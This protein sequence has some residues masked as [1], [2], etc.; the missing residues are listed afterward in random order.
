MAAAG[1]GIGTAAGAL[2]REAT[3]CGRSD[4][5]SGSV[6]LAAGNRIA[7]SP[8]RRRRPSRTRAPGSAE[9]ARPPAVAP[10][11]G[12]W[13]AFGARAG[14]PPADDVPRTADS[15]LRRSGRGRLGRSSRAGPQRHGGRGH[16]GGIHRLAATGGSAPSRDLEPGVQGTPAPRVAA[17]S[18]AARLAASAERWPEADPRRRHPSIRRRRRSP[19]EPAAPLDPPAPDALPVRRRRRHPG[20]LRRAASRRHAAPI[21]RAHGPAGSAAPGRDRAGMAAP[22]RRSTAAPHP[23]AEPPPTYVP[24]P[25]AGARAGGGAAGVRPRR[26]R[27]RRRAGGGCGGTCPRRLRTGRAARRLPVPARRRPCAGAAGTTCGSAGR[28]LVVLALPVAA[29]GATGPSG[30]SGVRVVSFTR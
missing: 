25:G 26:R 28:A 2:L 8:P 16:R 3:G 13:R 29:G 5:P 20:R 4:R 6:P 27:A 11:A 12:C 23:P 10:G 17:A 7:R 19:A 18:R 30:S 21:R 1:P 15:P 22:G 14:K 9:R 24:R